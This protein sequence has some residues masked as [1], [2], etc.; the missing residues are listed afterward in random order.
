MIM[1]DDFLY[2]TPEYAIE[3][4]DNIVKESGGFFGIRDRGLIESSLE[5]IKN[6]IYY[7]NIEDK[8]THLLYSI[9]K[10]HCFNDGN[11][12]AS[13]ALS[14]YFLLINGLDILIEKFIIEMENIVVDVADNKIDKELLF[15]VIE[16]IL[17]EEEY[18][19]ELKI[20]LINAKQA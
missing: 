8:L 15:E 1:I 16:S 20:K 2:F 10:N 12:R 17:Y 11:K 13:L 7:P 19:E 5:H 18:S 14:M 9:N 3:V 4:H 6:D